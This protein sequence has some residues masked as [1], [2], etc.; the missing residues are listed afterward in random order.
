MSSETNRR[1]IRSGLRD[2]G[3]QLSLLNRQVSARVEMKD[4]DLD[5]LDLIK[6]H[7]PLSPGALARR[8]GLHPATMTGVLDRLE[9]GGWISRERNPSDRRAV[10]IT[11]LSGRDG[12]LLRHFAGMGASVERICSA[13]DPAELE[14]IAGFL[15]RIADAGRTSTAELSGS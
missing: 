2:V 9:K 6:T 14:V 13:Y 3:L 4:V 10:Q 11:A 8:A 7:G 15:E 12:E 1:R 5:C